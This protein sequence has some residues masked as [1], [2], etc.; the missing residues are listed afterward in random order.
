MPSFEFTNVKPF[1]KPNSKVF[2]LDETTEPK[3]KQSK[4]GQEAVKVEADVTRSFTAY[5]TAT[6]RLIELRKFENFTNLIFYT[7]LFPTLFST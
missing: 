7:P 1:F 4:S 2:S 5:D 6:Q 3:S